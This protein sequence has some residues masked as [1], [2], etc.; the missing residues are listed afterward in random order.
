MIAFRKGFDKSS[1]TFIGEPSVDAGGPYQEFFRLLMHEI[2][3]NN[4]LFEGS[5]ISRVPFLNVLEL[6][7]GT[8]R[9]IGEII[10]LSVMHGGPGPHC[11]SQAVTDYFS[12][13]VWSSG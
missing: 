4:S 9:H 8:Y 7:K 10:A 6:Q 11:F 1:I 5:V 12:F 13:G 3:S 2:M